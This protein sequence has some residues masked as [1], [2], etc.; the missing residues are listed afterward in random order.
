LIIAGLAGQA[1]GANPPAALAAASGL[2][3]EAGLAVEL[4]SATR[5]SN[6]Q[7]LFQNLQILGRGDVPHGLARHHDAILEALFA[8]GHI[9]G[10][11]RH[12]KAALDPGGPFYAPFIV[13]RFVPHQSPVLQFYFFKRF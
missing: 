11:A 3:F 5:A 4:I 10:C 12:R 1:G 13:R 9:Q 7:G 6:F 8:A 2:V